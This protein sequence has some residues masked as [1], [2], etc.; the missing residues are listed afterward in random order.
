MK[1]LSVLFFAIPLA[2]VVSAGS[3]VPLPASARPSG[4]SA[5]WSG[6]W[7]Y[8]LVYSCDRSVRAA[9]KLCNANFGTLDGFT[10]VWNGSSNA[11][12]NLAF[13]SQ[14][15]ATESH[16]GKPRLC[17][18]SVYMNAIFNGSCSFEDDGTGFIKAGLTHL[19]DFWFDYEIEVFHRYPSDLTLRDP[20][21]PKNYPVD[22]GVQAVPGVYNTTQNLRLVGAIKP[23]QTAPPGIFL[24]IT[25]EHSTT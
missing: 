25:V 16:P 5:S 12:G 20:S 19:P 18:P 14:I 9:Q 17:T 8:V 7:R 10:W 6:R 24:E 4:K 13:T 11:A 21:G 15:V 22:V 3:A 1:R 2:L 23:N